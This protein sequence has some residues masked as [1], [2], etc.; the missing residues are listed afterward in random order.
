MSDTTL[1]RLL[2]RSSLIIGITLGLPSL[3]ATDN[4]D[5]IVA[6]IGSESISLS[7]VDESG[8]RQLHDKA[9]SL[10]EARVQ[11][12]YELLSDRLMAL[13][14]ESRGISPNDLQHTEVTDKVAPVTEA[15]IDVF[16]AQ[17]DLD[18]TDPR[19]RRRV[20]L[21]LQMQA[22]AD[23]RTQFMQGLFA[24]YGVSVT[25][26]APP[27][28]PPEEVAGDFAPALG[29][30][31]APIKV[32]SFIDYQCRHC[33]DMSTALHELHQRFP[34]TVQIV[35]RHF[36]LRPGAQKIAEAALCA[37]DQ[38]RFWD[39]HAALYATPGIVAGHTQGIAEDLSLDSKAF[40]DCLLQERHRLRVQED[41]Q[42]GR[43]LDITGTPTSFING[44]RIYGAAKLPAL[45]A[46][47]EALLLKRTDDV[48][49]LLR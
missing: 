13:E 49:T 25:L 17:Q 22:A 36:P 3:A 47:V 21:F 37:E 16:I 45:V 12:L 10:Y 9:Q 40:S 5:P 7:Q 48:D 44:V 20:S 2:V 14:A 8:G 15:A 46:Q 29:Q 28:P 38:D 43:R 11:S 23:Q 1:H 26:S 33:K 30:P 42:E 34:N 27:A 6:T 39:Y 41:I 4:G 32:I 35:Y 19:V 31:S 18:T 24:A